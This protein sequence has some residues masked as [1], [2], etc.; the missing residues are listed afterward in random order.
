MIDSNKIQTLKN[1]AGR[2][3]RHI[4]ANPT[5]TGFDG[6]DLLSFWEDN[7]TA[8]F[9]EIRD[10]VAKDI[11]SK[12]KEAR[13]KYLFCFDKSMDLRK[14][15]FF[16][17]IAFDQ[18]REF[19]H[20][21]AGKKDCKNRFLELTN[22]DF[23]RKIETL[24]NRQRGTK[25]NAPKISLWD[26]V[27]FKMDRNHKDMMVKAEIKGRQFETILPTRL[28][29]CYRNKKVTP[30][31]GWFLSLY[32][33][34]DVNPMQRSRVNESLADFFGLPKCFTKN[35]CNANLPIQRATRL[36][37]VQEIPGKYKAHSPWKK[38]P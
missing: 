30:R 5:G 9:A 12:F 1:R 25:R 10:N 23:L 11:C 33:R 3:R 36:H 13:E 2:L 18:K 16:E 7:F 35:G 14:F 17:D 15:G 34:L 24:I 21:E 32:Y 8:D 27:T 29:K 22:D 38:H 4:E 31:W 37:S 19:G 6:D 26:D 20:S 28:L